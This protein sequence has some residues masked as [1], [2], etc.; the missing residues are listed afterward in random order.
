[1]LWNYCLERGTWHPAVEWADYM[2]TDKVSIRV[3]AVFGLSL[4]WRERN[5]KWHD[6][7]RYQKEWYCSNVLG[8]DWMGVESLILYMASSYKRGKGEGKEGNCQYK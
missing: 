1:M 3:G 8:G 5:E 4:V 7:C 2:F 6:N